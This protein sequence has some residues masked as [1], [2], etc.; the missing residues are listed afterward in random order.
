MKE[1]ISR[2]ESLPADADAD[3]LREADET[4]IC[5]D[6]GQ[7]IYVGALMVTDCPACALALAIHLA[8]KKINDA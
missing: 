6:C 8:R 7:P 4:E 1:L 3:A 2:I 5:P